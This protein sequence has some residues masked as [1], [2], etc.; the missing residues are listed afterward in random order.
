MPPVLDR[1]LRGPLLLYSLAWWLATPALL[2]SLVWR[3]A[4]QR[5]YLFAVPERF[6]FVPMPPAA[7]Q[8]I[9]VHAGSVGETRAAEPLIRALAS[10]WP[11]AQILLTHMTPTGRDTGRTVLADLVQSGR[12]RQAWLPWDYPGATR[13]MLTRLRPTIGVL[14]ETELWPNLMAAATDLRVPIVLASARLSERSLAKGLRWRSLIGPALDALDRVFAQTPSD[15]GRLARLG[16]DAVPVFGN[17][18]FDIEAPAAML[19]RGALWRECLLSS[20]ASRGIILA[21]STRDGE[22]AM[23][24]E[25][26][27]RLRQSWPEAT[28]PLLVLVPRHPQRFDEVAELARSGRWSLIR[29]SAFGSEGPDPQAAQA[30]LILGDSM[31]EMFAW[32]AMADV[33]IIGGSLAPLGGQ[34]LIEAAAVGCPVLLGPHTFNFEEISRDAIEA[35]AA[36]RV[37]DAA[38]ALHAA[39]ALLRDEPRRSRMSELALAFARQHRGATQR[40][41]DAI[42]DLIPD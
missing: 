24:L 23:L 7:R 2:G 29:R 13:R 19:A 25:A 27:Q 41:V 14:M 6:G 3:G 4:R 42:A 1:R 21:A 28:R 9:W 40:T 12:L 26:W 5:G 18:K 10:R 36:L 15:A 8:L 20:K 37:G 22:E 16:R 33:A 17:L 30:D 34:N 31:G 39:E 38:G 11:A 32:Y 35:G